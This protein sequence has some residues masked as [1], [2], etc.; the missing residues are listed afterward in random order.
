VTALTILAR[1]FLRALLWLFMATVILLAQSGLW[2]ESVTLAAKILLVAVAALSFWRPRD[3]L[4]V[5]AG[6]AP[7]AVVGGRLLG[8]SPL[9]GPEAL[10]LAFLAGALL[11]GWR[12]GRLRTFPATRHELATLMVGGVVAASCVEQLWFLQLQLNYPWT[13][14]RGA[15]A[16]AAFDYL[17]TFDYYR[18]LFHSMLV[19]E[20]L[21]LL[22]CAVEICGRDPA[23]RRQLARVVILGGTGAAVLSLAAVLTAPLETGAWRETVWRDVAANRIAVH[24]GDVN[25]AGAYFALINLL[26]FARL[27][28]RARL[29]LRWLAPVLITAVALVLTRSRGAEIPWMLALAG[30]IVLAIRARAPRLTAGPARTVGIVLL[31]SLVTLAGIWLVTDAA[32]PGRQ[33]ASSHAVTVRLLFNEAS[34]RM[35]ASRPVFGVG[36]GQ[37]N[38]WSVRYYPAALKAMYPRENAHNGFLQLSAELGIVG[39]AALGFL[40]WSIVALFRRRPDTASGE[41]ALRAGAMAGVVAFLLS[42]A[43]GNQFVV[44]AVVYPLCLT[45]GFGAG[46]APAD[47]AAAPRSRLWPLVAALALAVSIPGRV[48]V[49]TGH[50]E[51]DRVR[52]G[53]YGTEVD[54]GGTPFQWTRAR[55]RFFFQPGVCEVTLP[56][57]ALLVGPNERDVEVAIGVGNRPGVPIALADNA[58]HEYRFEFPATPDTRYRYLDLQVARPWIPAEV[59]R[60]SSDPRE[61]GVMVGEIRQTACG[62]G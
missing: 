27:T 35:W 42:A 4:L 38:L 54:A 33:V 25:A 6:L 15:A 52:W 37:Y 53:L 14:L 49:E 19:F 7:L 31:V 47:G 11:H 57:R 5:V 40:A 13:F 3:G 18:M 32:P 2:A 62:T 22:L 59:I 39:V 45:L 26:A 9:R 58:W 29:R 10:V 61:L 28:E 20:G 21:A 23:F 30:L 46:P 51:L 34:A 12:S 43:G 36:I 1:I 60:G 24:I 50:I 56:V 17:V 8:A 55:A 16:Y 44:P 48:E 41:E